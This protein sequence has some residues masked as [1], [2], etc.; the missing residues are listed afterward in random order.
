MS[1]IMV[2]EDNEMV[3]AS[4]RIVLMEFRY[5]AL[6]AASAQPAIVA[7]GA[8][9]A[10][11]AVPSDHD[12]GH[13]GSGVVAGHA[14]GDL[15]DRSQSSLPYGSAKAGPAL[16][17]TENAVGKMRRGVAPTRVAT[18]S[19]VC[20]ILAGC[21]HAPAQNLLGSY[22][23]SWMICAVIGLLGTLVCRQVMVRTGLD[24][25]IP[26]KLLVYLALGLSLTFLAWLSWFAN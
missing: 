7:F 24:A 22:F 15:S 23:P 11:D 8:G 14:V 2:V 20:G 18:A 6:G 16:R 13:E 12:L 19:T 26:V 5:D 17:K 4:Y 3:R 10:S 25:V 9:I 21:N 1:A